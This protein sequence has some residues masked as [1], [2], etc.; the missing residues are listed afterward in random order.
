[1]ARG[2]GRARS[3]PPPPD[4]PRRRG[5]LGRGARGRAGSAHQE[6]PEGSHRALGGEARSLEG[7]ALRGRLRRAHPEARG[8]ARR[9]PRSP[10]G[11]RAMSELTMV[12]AINSGMREAMRRDPN[13]LLLGEDVGRVGGVFRVSD[14]LLEEFGASRVIDTPLSEGGLVGTAIG[15]AM[16][17]LRPIAEIQFADFI[18]PAI[19]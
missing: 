8:A 18:Y 7:L 9:V 3:H 11:A 16:H 4:S 1:R 5:G 19:D 13:V 10:R 6:R 14:G 17:G 12:E 15:M 2:V